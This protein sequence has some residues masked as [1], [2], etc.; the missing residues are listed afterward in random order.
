M[1]PPV[2]RAMANPAVPPIHDAQHFGMRFEAPTGPVSPVSLGRVRTL[3]RES[4]PETAAAVLCIFTPTGRIPSNRG[5]TGGGGMMTTA[6]LMVACL[7]LFALSVAV[8]LES[9]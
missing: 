3:T 7:S 2:L 4:N 1:A 8:L 5:T 6:V 9:R